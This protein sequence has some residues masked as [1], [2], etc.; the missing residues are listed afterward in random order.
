[1]NDKFNIIGHIKWELHDKDG[2][3]K[4]WGE[5]SN[6]VQHD[7][8]NYFSDMLVSGTVNTIDEMAIGSGS[9]QTAS[10]TALASHVSH[11]AI[12]SGSGLTDKGTDGVEAQASFTNVAATITEAGLFPDGY[13]GG[14]MYFYN[15]SAF[16]SG[17]T[18]QTSDTLTITWSI[19]WS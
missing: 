1:M 2:N 3:L 11:E 18:L 12:S 4:D 10:A 6:Q 9:G 17:V 7:V 5:H 16:G 13:A 8:M 14:K 15:D 19:S